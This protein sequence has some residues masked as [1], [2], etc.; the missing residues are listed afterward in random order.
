M[1]GETKEEARQKFFDKLYGEMHRKLGYF[2]FRTC[3]DATFA[4]DVLQETFMEAYRNIDKLMEHPEPKAWLYVAARNKMM[5]M[6]KKKNEL[7]PV[8]DEY[9]IVKTEERD[10]KEV[11][12]AEVIKSVVGEEDYNMLCDYFLNGYSAAEVARKYNVKEGGIR[13]RMSRLKKKLKNEI[14]KNWILFVIC[15]FGGFYGL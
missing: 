4:E 14:P 1:K 12:L 6:G 11:E 5:K 3:R 10:Y 9:L 15:M 8:D 7:C 2:I 13:M